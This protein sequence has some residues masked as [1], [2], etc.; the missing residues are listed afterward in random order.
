MV[1]VISFSLWGNQ[2]KYT[3]GAIKNADLAKHFYPEFQ[4]WFYIHKSTVPQNIIDELATKDNVK[5]FFKDGNLNVNKPMMWRFEPILDPSV[6]IMMSRD[7]DT[8]ILLRE[9]LA[10]DEWLHSD[11]LLHSMRDHPCHNYNIQGGMWGLKQN[12]LCNF[13]KLFDNVKQTSNYLYDQVFI[14]N[15]IYPIFKNTCMTHASFHKKESFDKDFP[16]PFC[17]NYKFVGEYV[18]ADESREQKHINL[19]KNNLLK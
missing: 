2:S 9:K 16:I 14:S 1:K 4:C 15:V 13:K 12:N 5:I 19:I 11:K 17:E 6:E 18:Y 10:V 8:R 3:I 7:T